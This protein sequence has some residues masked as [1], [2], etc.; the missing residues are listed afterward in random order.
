MVKAQCWSR[1]PSRNRRLR[2]RLTQRGAEI[3]YLPGERN[4]VD[5]KATD[6]GP[7]GAQ[8]Q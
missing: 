8:H 1:A 7:C 5:L 2:R 6:E 4:K 3:L